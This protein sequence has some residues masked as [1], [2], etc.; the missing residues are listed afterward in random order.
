[1]C[2][3]SKFASDDDPFNLF[4]TC[5]SKNDILKLMPWT[6]LLHKLAPYIIIIWKKNKINNISICFDGTIKI[7]FEP[8]ICY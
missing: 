4:V 5:T 1:M 3:R 6:I 8:P 2:L 7:C